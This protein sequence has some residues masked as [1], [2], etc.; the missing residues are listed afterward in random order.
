MPVP[1]SVEMWFDNGPPSVLSRSTGLVAR[2]RNAHRDVETWSYEAIRGL[3]VRVFCATAR[4]TVTA[5][6]SYLHPT[7]NL[8]TPDNLFSFHC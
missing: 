1:A 7:F 3:R 6:L 5:Q 8:F 4:G 2:I